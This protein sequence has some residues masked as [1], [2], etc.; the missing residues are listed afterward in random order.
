[1]PHLKRFWQ[2]LS[3]IGIRADTEASVKK[4]VNLQNRIFFIAIFATL[5]QTYNFWLSGILYVV[6]INTVVVI[7][8]ISCLVL[9]SRGHFTTARLFFVTV[10]SASLMHHHFYFGVA[11]GF[12]IMMLNLSQAPFVLFPRARLGILAML[13]LAFVIVISVATVM[14]LKMPAIYEGMTVA[15]SDK[16]FYTNLYRSPVLLLLVAYYL[17]SGGRTAEAELTHSAKKATEAAQAKTLF[18]SNI[19]HELRTPLNAITGFA[20][21]LLARSDAA[22]IDSAKTDY[23]RFLQQILVSS[24]NLTAIIG[25]MLD[26]ARIE[27]NRI[28]F[29]KLPFNLREVSS[30]AVDTARFYGRNQNAVETRTWLHPNLP[31]VLEGDAVRLTQILVNL[32]GNAMKFTHKGYV[33]LHV[34]MIDET[35]ESVNVQFEIEDTGIGIPTEKLPYLF[36]SLSPVSRE[37]AIRYGGTGLGLAITKQ[38]VEMQGGHIGVMS[39]P[40]TGS[41]FTVSLW[42]KKATTANLPTAGPVRNLKGVRILAAEDNE[43]NQILVQTLIES[44]QGDLEIVDNGLKALGKAQQHDY[45]LILMDL[46]MPFMDGLETTQNIRMFD[47]PRKATIPI[48]ALTADVLAE[49]R[50]KVFAVGMNDIVTKP[51][52]QTELFEAIEK[53]LGWRI[54]DRPSAHIHI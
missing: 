44:W 26:F 12:W 43:V 6:A 39:S 27:S 16:F 45:D 37:T 15:M 17:V 50:E 14:S 49:T 41:L 31:E 23:K 7:S 34:A 18:L 32:L 8:Y 3:D 53:V 29:K 46:Q 52:N 13:S 21:I 25:D 47:D 20:E 48:I 11:S 51:I 22:I 19:S 36:D 42:F 2:I 5:L 54:P 30:H 4:L 1:M 24:Q 35:K 40:K 38:L 9:T 33:Q 10:A 28:D